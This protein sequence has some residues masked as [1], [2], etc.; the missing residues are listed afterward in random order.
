MYK[1]KQQLIVAVHH[2]C[3]YLWISFCHWLFRQGSPWNLLETKSTRSYSHNNIESRAWQWAILIYLLFMA[4]DDL[5]TMFKYPDTSESDDQS[6][7][8][9]PFLGKTM[10]KKEGVTRWWD[11]PP[12][13]C[14]AGSSEKRPH[15]THW[16]WLLTP[17]PHFTQADGDVTKPMN[18]CQSDEQ[19]KWRSHRPTL[20]AC[21]F[22]F[23]QN[24]PE[25]LYKS[26]CDC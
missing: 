9:E 7:I 5:I 14:T 17:S 26:W 15:A 25:F 18:C 24:W 20:I 19:V 22:F 10:T 13:T 21:Y 23:H 2:R 16:D 3:V 12:L 4:H 8:S 1:S 6:S 11:E